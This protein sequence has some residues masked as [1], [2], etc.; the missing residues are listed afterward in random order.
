MWHEARKQEK[1]LRET[2]VNYQKRAERRREHYDKLVSCY[3]VLYLRIVLMINHRIVLEDFIVWPI[4]AGDMQHTY[5]I[6]FN[7]IAEVQYT[8]EYFFSQTEIAF[9]V[10]IICSM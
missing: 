7:T 4:A 10:D 5:A 3:D 8:T 2:M 6:H 1:K 9:C